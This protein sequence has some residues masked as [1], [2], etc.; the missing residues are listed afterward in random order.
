M[1]SLESI[2][3][4]LDEGANEPV[5][6][7]AGDLMLAEPLGRKLADAIAVRGD[8]RVEVVRRPPRLGDLLGDL[9]TYSLFAGCRVMLVVESALL[10]D[11]RAAAA[12]LD[13]VTEVLPISAV[14]A[15]L[16]RKE[17]AAAGRLLQVFRLFEIDPYAGAPNE[18]V[19]RLP[20]WAFEG[21]GARQRKRTKA[22]VEEL[23]TE[24]ARLLE[25]AR[26]AGLQGSA[27]SDLS[28]LAE[29]L[30]NGLPAGHALVL[31]ESSVA[32]DHP[33]VAN[34][35]RRRAVLGA[36][37]VEKPRRG[38][39]QGVDSLARQLEEETGSPIAPDALA[40]L[41]LRTLRQKD[42]RSGRAEADST[43]KFA[44]E[45]RK[46]ASL[47]PGETIRLDSVISVVEDRGSENDDVWKILDAIGEGKAAEALKR[48][49]RHLVASPNPEG[50]RFRL[51]GLLAG[52]CRQLTAVSGVM[53]LHDVP[54]GVSS[55]PKFKS[56]YAP[57]LQS[58]LAA[59]GENP[60]KELHPY[61]LH[62]VYLAA[63]R[64]PD[65]VVS[66]LQWRVLETE[67]RLKGESRDAEA[68]L[69]LLITELSTAA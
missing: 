61:R 62:K 7:V 29:V 69:A 52:F 23:R 13:E 20:A 17:R 59:G 16:D 6:L 58:E 19:A 12:L 45:Y 43:A 47:A 66:D 28:E 15:E 68:A 14:D 50:D 32:K 55:Y 5:Y 57:R 30:E 27:E 31:V 56:S 60:L 2:L 9:R 26:L 63:S 44:A 10:A 4:S 8:A 46:L 65:A 53:R 3:A 37:Q 25:M 1:S 33:L 36:G 34:L 54:R 18:V 11:R 41:T 42:D 39:W 48:I 64:L 51:L 40:E 38:G 21:G 49:D 24:T 22:K 35:V 67:L